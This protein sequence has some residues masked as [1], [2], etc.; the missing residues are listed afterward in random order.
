MRPRRAIGR[1][2]VLALLLAVPFVAQAA[3]TPSEG[4]AIARLWCS[5]CHIV[6]ADQVVGRTDLPTFPTIAMRSPDAITA[7]AAFLADPHPPMPN[8]SLTREEIRN[9]LAYIESLRPAR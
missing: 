1:I 7:L 4:E 6:A 9:I 5:G 2:S 8:M 3:G